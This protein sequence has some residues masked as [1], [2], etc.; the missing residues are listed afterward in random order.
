V[1]L[2]HLPIRA[3]IRDLLL[4]YANWPNLP[5]GPLGGQMLFYA[6]SIAATFVAAWASYHLYEKHFLKMKQFFRMRPVPAK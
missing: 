4:P 2:F 6:V 3:A 1:V 5:G